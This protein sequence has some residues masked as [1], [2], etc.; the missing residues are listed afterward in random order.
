MEF[1]YLLHPILLVYSTM[2]SVRFMAFYFIL[3]FVLPCFKWYRFKNNC[4]KC[5]LST[6]RGAGVSKHGSRLP[7]GSSLASHFG[8]DYLNLSIFKLIFCFAQINKTLF[9]LF[10]YGKHTSSFRYFFGKPVSDQFRIPKLKQWISN[11]LYIYT[12]IIQKKKPSLIY[13]KH[14]DGH[15]VLTVFEKTFPSR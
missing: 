14:E 7:V 4:N 9:F 2:S 15:N 10:F 13:I 12:L 1:K 5:F 3:F 11:E 8:K 6:C